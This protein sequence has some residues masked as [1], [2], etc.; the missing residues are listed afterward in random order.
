MGMIIG[1]IATPGNGACVVRR[2][3]ETT[4]AGDLGRSGRACGL[5]R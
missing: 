3:G 4:C 1:S 5:E 2:T